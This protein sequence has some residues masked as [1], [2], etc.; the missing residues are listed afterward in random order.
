MVKYTSYL[1]NNL[2]TVFTCPQV[3]LTLG[4]SE[5]ESFSFTLTEMFN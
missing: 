1:D 3:E 5:R 2:H 4:K